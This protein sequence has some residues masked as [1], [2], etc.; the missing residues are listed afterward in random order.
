LTKPLGTLRTGWIRFQPLRSRLS[1]AS[2]AVEKRLREEL[3]KL[4]VEGNEEKRR[5]VDLQR[6]E[7]CEFLALEFRRVGS[8]RGRGMPL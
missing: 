3:A 4:L 5:K 6:G 1:Q 7:S 2:R 8:R